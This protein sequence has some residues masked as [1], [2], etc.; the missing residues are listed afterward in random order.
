MVSASRSG[1]SSDERDNAGSTSF[2]DSRPQDADER[3]DS[4]IPDFYARLGVGVDASHEEL[5]HAY[6]RLVKLWHPDRYA[7]ATDDMHAQA[8]RRMRQLNEAYRTLSDP[9][10]R[11]E[12]DRQRLGFH[13]PLGDVINVFG[14]NYSPPVSPFDDRESA[15]V[16]SNPNG[17]GQFFGMLALVVA[18]ALIGGVLSGAGSGGAYIVLTVGAIVVIL[19]VAVT[20]FTSGSPLAQWAT[21]YMEAEPRGAPTATGRL[22]RKR[23]PA[24]PGPGAPPTDAERFEALIDEALT[25]VPSQFDEYLRNVV[26]RAEDEPDE[27]TLRMAGVPPGHTLLGLYHGVSLTRRGASATSPEVIT[28]YRGP[29]ERYCGGDLARIRMQVRSTVLHELA[30]HFG[31]DHDE[32]PEWVK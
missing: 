9:V 19:T 26:V 8:E 24:R 29:I 13:T 14:Q 16:R 25:A 11:A 32:M 27:E 2:D 1:S 17:A 28:I 30:H 12:Y 22:R 10:A 18:L 31:I 6:H 4:P 23:P 21:R 15:E 7:S 20:L 3:D 5:R